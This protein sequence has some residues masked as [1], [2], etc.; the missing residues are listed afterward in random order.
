ML[1][2]HRAVIDN[3]DEI[4]KNI[5]N[6]GLSDGQRKLVEKAANVD[7]TSP[8]PSNVPANDAVLEQLRAALGQ[9]DNSLRF[10]L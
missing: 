4:V 7:A 1:N 3:I 10:K 5:Y 8:K 6:Q 9:V 2:A